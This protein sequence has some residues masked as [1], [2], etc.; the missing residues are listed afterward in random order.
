MAQIR[1]LVPRKRQYTASE[2][3]R[4]SGLYPRTV[5][6][7]EQQSGLAKLPLYGEAFLTISEAGEQCENADDVIST[8]CFPH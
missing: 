7:N 6:L 1:H 4:S 5:L 2:V 8:D 3:F